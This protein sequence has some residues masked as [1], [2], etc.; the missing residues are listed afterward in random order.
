MGNSSRKL[1]EEKLL[2]LDRL[3]SIGEL[4]GMIA[5][6]LRNPLQ[7]IAG[8]TYYLKAKYA[9]TL[10][11]RGTEM[12]GIIEESINYS[13]KIITDLLEYSREITLELVPTTPK[14]FMGMALVRVHVP[15]NIQIVDKT[16]DTI[17]VSADSTK[18]ARVF[19]NLITNAFDAMPNGGILTVTSKKRGSTVAISFEDIGV[20]MNKET[21]KKIWVPLFTTK[22][23]GMGFGLSI[24]K[25]I[26]EAHGGK[27]TVKSSIGK[28]TVFK[29]SLPINKGVSFDANNT[30]MAVEIRK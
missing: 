4:A 10:D 22:A 11:Q 5:H 26:V 13:N 6:D 21:L 9:S 25:R 29:I 18:L 24:C 20:G 7:S 1:L 2:K 27:I 3:A 19:V 15:P 16:Q 12:L 17:A 23:K 8:A 14:T 28:G 30:T